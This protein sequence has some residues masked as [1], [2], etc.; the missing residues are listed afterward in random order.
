MF[1]DMPAAAP[2]FGEEAVAADIFFS[3]KNNH[4]LTFSWK[5]YAYPENGPAKHIAT[6]TGTTGT[7]IAPDSEYYVDTLSISS[8]DWFKTVVSRDNGNDRIA[9]LAFWLCGYK[10]IYC[11][12]TNVGGGGS[13][14]TSVTVHIKTF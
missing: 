2:Q 12:I 6:G 5:L 9:H 14:A 13:E 4:S 3:A 8:Q 1:S 7:A 10:Y 11:E